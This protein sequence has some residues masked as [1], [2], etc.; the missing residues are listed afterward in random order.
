MDGK[1][2]TEKPAEAWTPWTRYWSIMRWMALVAV[3]AVLAALAWFHWFGP[4]LDI[5]L[6]LATTIGIGLTI[7]MA[8]ALMGL[9][10]LSSGT[11]HD[12][13]IDRHDTD[14]T[15]RR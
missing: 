10:F 14:E 1:H 9:V 2:V 15:G 13:N 4:G 3:A 8:A 7:M 6:I 11:G 12:E 5:H